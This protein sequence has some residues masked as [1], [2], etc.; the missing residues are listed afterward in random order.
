MLRDAVIS[1]DGKY[2]YVLSRR[3]GDSDHFL[4]FIM[5]N[6]S[7]ADGKVD[8]PTIRRCIS[9]AKR[10]GFDGI[11]VTNLFAY[12]TFDPQILYAQDDPCGPSN[13]FYISET[14]KSSSM[15]CAAWGAN[16]TTGSAIIHLSAFMK[17]RKMYCL[18]VTKNGSPRHPLYV[19][20]E[21]PFVEFNGLKEAV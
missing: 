4:N 20:G 6:P 1:D 18:G 12:R 13:P 2:R 11:Y 15:V 21:Q 7:T 10:N 16:K 3:W 17:G 9:F 14:I 8:D 5:L 19:R